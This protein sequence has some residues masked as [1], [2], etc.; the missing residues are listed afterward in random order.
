MLQGRMRDQRR[1]LAKAFQLPP[2]NPASCFN[3][4]LKRS[5]FSLWQQSD[6]MERSHFQHFVAV[7][8]Y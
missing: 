8:A 1:S 2:A 3:M 5:N 7:F 4:R 6:R